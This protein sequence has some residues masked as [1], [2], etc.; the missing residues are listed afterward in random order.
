LGQLGEVADNSFRG[1]KKAIKN[2]AQTVT[3]LSAVAVATGGVYYAGYQRG[4]NQ[5]SQAN[6]AG[7]QSLAILAINNHSYQ[8][9]TGEIGLFNLEN[10]PLNLMSIESSKYYEIINQ[11]KELS[12]N[13]KEL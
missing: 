2:P 7:Q 9:T 3:K 8:N 6:S 4:Y 11:N 12:E 5:G 13:N 1:F 10:T